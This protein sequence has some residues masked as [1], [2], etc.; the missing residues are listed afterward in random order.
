MGAFLSAARATPRTFDMIMAGIPG[1]LS[2]SYVSAMFDGAQRGSTL[3]YT[4][5]HTASLDSL[6]K[7]ATLAPDGAARRTAWRSVQQALDS[8]APATWLYHAHGLQGISR[9]VQGVHM[10]LRGELVTLHDWHI[11]GR[12]GAS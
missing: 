12:K 11:P 9:R 2:L 10:D 6:L 7:Q 5:F 1:D 4:A 3:D 8:L